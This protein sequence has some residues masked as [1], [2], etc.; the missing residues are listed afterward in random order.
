MPLARC[1]ALALSLTL[2]VSFRAATPP[3]ISPAGQPKLNVL[4]LAIDDL[5]NE[6]G[7]LGAPHARTPN[8]DALARTSRIFT[9]HYVQ[10]PTCGASRC[11]LLRGRY[12]TEVAQVN[13][14]G[15]RDTHAAWG[16]QSLPAA[17]K[18]QG[19]RTL[20][21]GKITH[22]PGNLTGKGWA[23]GPEEMPGVWE[24]SWIPRGP[25]S[26]PEAIMHGY[27]NGGARVPGQSPA[28]ELHDGGDDAYPDHWVANDAVATL[29]E[30]AAQKQPWFFGVGFFKPHLPFNAPK[31]WHDLYPDGVPDLSSDVAAKPTWPSG[32]NASGEFRNNYSHAG[33]DP[34]TDP[35]YARLLRRAYAASVSYMDAQL[36]RVLAALRETGQ[37]QN[38]VVVLWGDHGFLLGE[39]AIWGKHCLYEEALRSPLLIRTPGLR[40]P[41]GT[42][43]ALVETVD[44]FP[45]LADLCGLPAPTGLDGR[46][47]RAQLADPAAP[48]AKPA[49]GFWTGGARTVRTER[50]R[51][52]VD[53]TNQRA[54]LF[55]YQ[56]DPQ[57]TRNVASAQ[58]A[59]VRDLLA[60]LDLV[61]QPATSAAGPT[62]QK[63]RAEN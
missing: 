21:L 17:F 11:A 54:E 32:W 31:K 52:I 5:R 45:T 58:T 47:L 35:A 44:I 12:P 36:G 60:R 46:S 49:H 20:S 51:L 24:R 33:R 2:I 27:A 14:N 61:P 7:A 6:L 63:S 30:L 22:Y 19:Y 4:F 50:W 25:W 28:V 1:F 48:T 42:S 26:T 57:E 41:G 39:H 9:H 37:D 53:G 62:K 10:V 3:P 18:A 38:T 34:A 56:A 23:T 55:D 8:I 59:V 43:A 29:R 40:Q 16:A 15:I 13:N